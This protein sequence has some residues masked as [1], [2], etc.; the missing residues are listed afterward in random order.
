MEGLASPC[1]CGW[2]KLSSL[3][4]PLEMTEF[5]NQSKAN[6][7]TTTKPQPPASCYL[8]FQAVQYAVLNISAQEESWRTVGHPS[9]LQCAEP[10]KILKLLNPELHI[11][12]LPEC[13]NLA[14][15][16]LTRYFRRKKD[17]EEVAS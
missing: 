14:W 12:Q 11:V 17:V 3:A 4:L 15:L 8:I 2:V 7:Q 6:K 5:E 1:L 16:S 9:A 13:K 10:P